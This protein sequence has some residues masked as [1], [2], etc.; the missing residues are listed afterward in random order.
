MLFYYFH[1]SFYSFE[2]RA[3]RCQERIRQFYHRVRVLLTKLLTSCKDLF[4]KS[5]VP[6]GMD[7]YRTGSDV[8][9]CRYLLAGS[10]GG[11]P[12]IAA[13]TAEASS[14]TSPRPLWC[15]TSLAEKCVSEQRAVLPAKTGVVAVIT[16]A[17]P[18]VLSLVAAGAGEQRKD[19]ARGFSRDVER[20]RM[21]PLCD[22]FIGEVRV[23]RSWVNV[24]SSLRTSL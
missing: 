4:C 13:E 10:G 12:E 9:C 18:L 19:K 3:T 5:A 7:G 8:L 16:L 14:T 2:Y 21:R 1:Y 22:R 24:M 20:S 11:W 6:N 15:I 23:Q 17:L